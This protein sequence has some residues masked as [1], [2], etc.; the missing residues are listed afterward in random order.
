MKDVRNG[1]NVDESRFPSPIKRRRLG[2][3][4]RTLAAACL[5]LTMAGGYTIAAS[6]I[7]PGASAHV[8]APNKPCSVV[9]AESVGQ[10]FCLKADPGLHQVQLTWNPSAPVKS[11][12]VYQGDAQGNGQPAKVINLTDKSAVVPRLADGIPYYF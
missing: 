5:V 6:G 4:L 9:S 7:T 3:W 10:W 8:L 11:V 12:T 2:R 1:G